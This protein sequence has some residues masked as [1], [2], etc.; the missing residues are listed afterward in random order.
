MKIFR[1][2][3]AAFA[4]FAVHALSLSSSW[5]FAAEPSPPHV[6]ESG[7]AE[8]LVL[9][10]PNATRAVANPSSVIPW[11]KGKTPIAPA[12]FDVSL[13]ADELDNPRMIY[14]LPN[15]DVLVMESL[16]QQSESR[17]VLLRDAAKSG[18]PT[19]RQPFLRRLHMAFGM[20]L[21]GNRFFVGNTDAI[22]VFPYRSGETQ[23]KRRG[24]KVLDLP[25]G[26]HYTRNLLADS[27][28][29][30]IYV[31]VGSATN[32]DEQRVDEKEPRRAAILQINADGSA[33][34][35]FANGMRNPVGMDWQ[36]T[37]NTLWAVVNERDMLGD[38]LVP[39]YLTSVRD[40][41]FYGWPY[42]YFG[43]NED[44][45]KK[46]Q[47]PD[48]VAK[49]IKPDY[50][51]GSHVAPLGL[52]FYHGKSFPQ[53]YHD[54]AFIGM[55]G[56]WNRSNLVGYKVAFVPFQNGKPS[57]AL[58]DF[59]TGF[60]ANPKT[61]EVYGRPVGV[62]VWTDGSLLVADDAAGKIWRVSVKK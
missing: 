62:A 6:V 14:V 16:P 2:V 33:M 52:A 58:E 54:G 40:G 57:G 21:I 11:P 55:H 61:S 59:L 43:Q 18:K 32:V 60:I 9:P 29:K 53:H 23:I 35:V 24:E 46:G 38:E 25:A 51:L 39:D 42:S 28:G 34:R 22:V 4:F 27:D 26:G 15:G 19:L 3:F 5:L 50:A 1:L 45:R 10:P 44:P 37:T 17:I 13:F 48:L 56:S 47:R 20:A 8:Q 7:P 36:P 49:A 12:G 30:K 41:A 31:A